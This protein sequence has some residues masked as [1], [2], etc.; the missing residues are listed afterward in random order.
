M[1]A[2]MAGSSSLI[3]VIVPVYN[4]ERYVGACIDS[5]MGQRDV[6]LEMLLVDDGSTD[7]S[8]KICDEHAAQ[9]D[10]VRVFHTVNRGPSAARNTGIEHARGEL[11]LFLDADDTLMDGAVASLAGAFD[12]GDCELVVGNFQNV[13]VSGKTSDSPGNPMEART[14][15]RADV[16]DY[17][18]SYLRKPNRFPL[19]AYSWGRLFVSSIIKNNHIAFNPDL[20]TFEDVAFNF[21]YMKH[22]EHMV[23]LDEPVCAH[24]VHGNYGS[25][26]TKLTGRPDHLFGYRQALQSI[27]SFLIHFDAFEEARQELGHAYVVLTIIQLVRTCGQYNRDNR[28]VIH[29]LVRDIVNDPFTRECLPCYTPS[30]RD[31]RVLPLLFKLKLTLPIVLVCKY[32]AQK[33][34]G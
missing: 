12:D 10:R 8:G 9:N 13:D 3:S 4:A 19:F 22:V 15:S 31:S 24:L 30:G 17:A 23:F 33:R 34:Y 25:A 29:A 26:T 21:D 1:L 28:A 7:G 6:E 16:I 11:I 18:R 27:K 32:K 5:T 20:R 2:A 14:M